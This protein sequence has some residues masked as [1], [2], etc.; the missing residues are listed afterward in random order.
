MKLRVRPSTYRGYEQQVRTNLRPHLGSVP[1][2]RL[3]PTDVEHMQ[4]RLMAAGRAPRTAKIARLVLS[5]AIGD[6]VRDGLVP[7]NVAKLARPPRV[8]RPEQR[9]LT[10]PQARALM[11][12]TMDDPNGPLYA[13]ALASGL[14]QGELLGLTWADLDI[15][16][17]Q[18]TVRR[19]LARDAHGG[20]SLRPPKTARSRRTISLPRLGIDAVRRQKRR[21][22]E[23]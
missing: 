14:R 2:A 11:A 21:Q 20:F 12:N 7:R 19:S 16:A 5:S 4:A 17:G 23:L 8:E 6:A 18:L 22:A 3:T 9:V 13:L 1:L 10:A 15:D